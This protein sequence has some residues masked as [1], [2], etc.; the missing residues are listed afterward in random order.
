MIPSHTKAARARAAPRQNL[1]THPTGLGPRPAS[2]PEG[3]ALRLRLEPGRRE[4]MIIRYHQTGL[5]AEWQWQWQR[6]GL[7]SRF[8]AHWHWRHGKGGHLGPAGGLW[9]V[10]SSYIADNFEAGD[11]LGSRPSRWIPRRQPQLPW[12]SHGPGF[13]PV[14]YPTWPVLRNAKPQRATGTE[15]PASEP[16]PQRLH[17]GRVYG[18]AQW[19]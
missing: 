8:S 6:R 12:D 11:L 17:G 16:K 3:R 2:E 4:L 9:H 19:Q 1:L 7:L 14:I 5:R 18:R 15:P 10:T 13:R